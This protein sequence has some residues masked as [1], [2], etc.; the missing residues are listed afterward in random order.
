MGAIASQITSLTIA[1]SAVYSDADQRKHQ[2]SASL[3]FVRGI[4]RSPH[5]W[6]VPRKM[7]PFDDV[8]MMFKKQANYTLQCYISVIRS[9]TWSPHYRW[10]NIEE[11]RITHHMNPPNPNKVTTMKQCP[12][13]L[14]TQFMECDVCQVVMHLQWSH[15]LLSFQ[16]YRHSEFQNLVEIPKVH[17]LKL[18]GL[19][20]EDLWSPSP[21][22]Q[23]LCHQDPFELAASV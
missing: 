7:F 19:P 10:I 9:I 22:R 6:P 5:K 14:C 16:T 13:K 17:F 15:S 12:T 23:D 21:K 4:N 3:A 2:S 11:C 18:T 20:G 8:I 1:Y